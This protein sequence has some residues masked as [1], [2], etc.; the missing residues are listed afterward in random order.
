MNAK[1][2]L[3]EKLKEIGNIPIKCADIKIITYVTGTGL[4]PTSD[5]TFI[6]RLKCG[7]KPF[8]ELK[9]YLGLDFNFN[10][11]WGQQIYGTVWLMNDT[12][13]ERVYDY[14]GAE[15]WVH[16]IYPEIPEFLK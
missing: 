14:D 2:E 11:I 12:H 16:K 1:D 15:R 6:I 8:N 9:F 5:E 3:I 7:Y 10:R 13:L 4:P